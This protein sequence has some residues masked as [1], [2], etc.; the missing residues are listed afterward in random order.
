MVDIIESIKMGISRFDDS[1]H[2][3]TK[4]LLPWFVTGTLGDTDRA[5]VQRHLA[6]C[7][8]CR[9]DLRM[10]QAQARKIRALPGDVDQGW[11]AMKARI[12]AGQADMKRPQPR[13]HARSSRRLVF[14]AVAFAAAAS[15]AIFLLVKPPPLYRTLGASPHPGIGNV[16][17]KFKP[18][19]SEA[20][21]R[22]VL[23][24]NHARIV[25]GPTTSDAYVLHVADDQRAAALYRLRS[26]SSVTVAEPIDGDMR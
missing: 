16:I 5:L 19:T 11:A 14:G 25:D 20:I 2:S 21:L 26:N 23:T 15:V 7:A 9:E 13:Q 10:E 24:Q 12:E 6:E 22:T 4:L 8:E 1:P 17:V 3:Q 18:D